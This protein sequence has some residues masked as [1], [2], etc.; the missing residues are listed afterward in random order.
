MTC[1]RELGLKVTAGLRTPTPSQG[2]SHVHPSGAQDGVYGGPWKPPQAPSEL[3]CLLEI[4]EAVK[5]GGLAGGPL[6]LGVK[7]PSS[8][9]LFLAGFVF[10]FVSETGFLCVG[11]P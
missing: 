8:F 9:M 5:T 6:S 3:G 1:G 2:L 4:Y 11:L 7:I 10:V